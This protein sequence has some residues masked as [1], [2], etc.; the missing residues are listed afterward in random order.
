MDATEIDNNTTTV[1]AKQTN[2]IFLLLN[3]KV[4]VFTNSGS[5]YEILSRAEYI[6]FGENSWSDG[7][8][9]W[10]YY[11]TSQDQKRVPIELETLWYGNLANRQLMTV[12]T[13]YVELYDDNYMP[14]KFEISMDSLMNN[15]VSTKKQVFNVKEK[16]YDRITKT[17][18]I[19]FQPSTQNTSA[20]KI[21]INS[22]LPI[23]RL[24]VGY[25][26]E[27]IPLISKNN[28]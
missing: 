1:F 21:N 18:Y 28:I 7:N 25:S 13:I 5:M 20:F 8:K 6:T 12:D 14:G 24:A 9:T 15:A 3:D 22:E 16:D 27:G 4:V 2:D 23:K 26:T 19:R 10:S 11:K 17:V